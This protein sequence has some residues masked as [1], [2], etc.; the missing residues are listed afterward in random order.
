MINLKS[1]YVG[2][3]H[4][5][6]LQKMNELQF[7]TYEGYGL[8]QI[9]IDAE[10]AIKKEIN[11]PNSKVYFLTG[12]TITNKVFIS[13]VLKP[14]EAVI[15]TDCGHI[16]VHETG[17]IEQ[18]GHKILTVCH[19]LGKIKPDQIKKVVLEHTDEHMVKPKLVYITDATEYGTIYSKEELI[20]ISNVCRELNLYLFL[21][22][23]RLGVAMVSEE[24]DLTLNDLT[25]LTDAFYIGGTKNGALL[26]EALIINNP[27]LQNEFR[28]SIKHYGGLYAKGFVAGIQFLT[29][30]TDNLFYDIAN[31]QVKLCTKLKKGLSDL[32]IKFQIETNTNQIFPILTTE[33]L[34]KINNSIKYSIWEKIDDTVVIR[35]VT[36]YLLT[37]KDIDEV[38][39]IFKD[40]L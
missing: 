39:K 11:S 17:T 34:N 13:H 29:L 5:K 18:G 38:I 20:A 33:I 15:S 40:I 22:G 8:D 26:G 4:P 9:S 19:H 37:E 7:N 6:I 25:K 10:V 14:Y 27:L 32:G 1:D 21:D 28:Y 31:Y 2:I 3:A 36:H 16:N 35:L 23:A 30:F 12:G 24:N